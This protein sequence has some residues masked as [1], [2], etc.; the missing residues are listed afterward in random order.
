MATSDLITQAIEPVRKVY[1]CEYLKGDGGSLN[2]GAYTTVLYGSLIGDDNGL[3]NTTTGQLTAPFDGILLI[4]ANLVMSSVAHNYGERMIMR[5]RNVTKAIDYTLDYKTAHATSAVAR[6]AG[7]GG[8]ASGLKVD[9]G[10]VLEVQAF[11][12]IGG[13]WPTITG[14][15]NYM[16]A[17]FIEAI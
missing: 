13:A 6:N 17:T 9:A 1:C 3:Y 4:S 12:E 2:D 14:T 7:M 15:F 16:S 11:Q 10:D 5:V 8:S